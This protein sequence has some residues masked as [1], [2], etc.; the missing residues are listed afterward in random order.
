MIEFGKTN[1]KNGSRISKLTK[2]GSQRKPEKSQ[3][4]NVKRWPAKVKVN[5]NR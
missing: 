4:V 1:V 5:A 2:E 3:K